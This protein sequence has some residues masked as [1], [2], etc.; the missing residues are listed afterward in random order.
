VF[1]PLTRA[2][3]TGAVAIPPLVGDWLEAW[4]ATA[5]CGRLG[6]R[7]RRQMKAALPSTATPNRS[8]IASLRWNSG[9]RSGGCSFVALR[10]D[11]MYPI[12]T[13]RA[14]W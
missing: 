9:A 8:T 11:D 4:S 10:R 7:C 2:W 12:P 6:I 1:R 5:S 3:A 14:I 13:A